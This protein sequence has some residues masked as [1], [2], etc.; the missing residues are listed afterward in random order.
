[1]A[2]VALVRRSVQREIIALLLPQALGSQL[3]LA[4][5]GVYVVLHWNYVT[6]DLYPRLSSAVKATLWTVFLLTTAYEILQAA[7]T[8]YWTGA[9]PQR[10]R[11][12][13]ACC[14]LTTHRPQ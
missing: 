2:P 5:F 13:D 6:S 7:D 8:L 11:R 1:M 9:F 10:T 12:L 14:P 4:L 3:S